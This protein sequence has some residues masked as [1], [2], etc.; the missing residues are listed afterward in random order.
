MDLLVDDASRHVPRI[1]DRGAGELVADQEGGKGA[2]RL[3]SF[4]LLFY[5]P[6]DFN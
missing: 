3:G 6:S 4:S 1:R 5:P 2:L